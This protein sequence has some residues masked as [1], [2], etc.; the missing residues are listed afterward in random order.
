M[1][2]IP[3]DEHQI[4]CFDSSCLLAHTKAAFTSQDE[5]DLVVVRLDVKYIGTLSENVDVAGQVSTVE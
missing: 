5:N 4:A 1:H 2:G 3:G